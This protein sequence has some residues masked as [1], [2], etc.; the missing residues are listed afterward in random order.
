MIHQSEKRNLEVSSDCERQNEFSNFEQISSF[1]DR[2][3]ALTF[4]ATMRG[5]LHREI[6]TF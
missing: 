3:Y 1:N 2:V 4:D 6:L 5:T